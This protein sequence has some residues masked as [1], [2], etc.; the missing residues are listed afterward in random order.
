MNIFLYDKTFEGFLSAIFYSYEMK[1][2]PDKFLDEHTYQSNLFADKFKIASEEIK[3][4]RVWSFLKKKTSSVTCQKV[5]AVFLSEL[6]DVEMLLYKFIKLA[7]DTPFNIEQNY[8]DN[9]VLQVNGIYKK[10]MREA[11]RVLMF[12][13]FQKTSDGIYYASFEPMY[14]VLPFAIKHFKDRF[15]DQKWIIY[16]TKRDYGFFY[17]LMTVKEVRIT[18]S[19]IDS[20]SGKLDENIMHEEENLFQELWQGYFDSI[21]IKERKNPKVHMQF[22]PKR[23]WK[24]L[25]EKNRL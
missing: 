21:N 5:H 14:N 3:A 19:K 24:Y 17:N 22:L 9:I 25:P 10:V 8:S 12:V 4:G 23:F 6:M 1:I 7:I 13:R 20:S 11:Q 16:D 15:S 2:T 18:E